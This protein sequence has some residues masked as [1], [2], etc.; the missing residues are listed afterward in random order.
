MKLAK[1]AMANAAAAGGASVPAPRASKP[2][3]K[4]TKAAASETVAGNDV[5]AATLATTAEEAHQQIAKIA[6]GYWAARG[7]QGGS[8]SEDWLRAEQE[9]YGR[10]ALSAGR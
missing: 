4:K 1:K 2:S 10:S 6:Y 5:A 3:A 9:Y 7:F 8:Q